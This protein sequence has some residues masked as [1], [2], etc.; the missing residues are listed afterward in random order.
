MA[1]KGIALCLLLLHH[2]FYIQK[3]LYDDIFIGSHGLVNEIGK[4]SK[5]CVSIFVFLSGYGLTRK[6]EL[7]GGLGSLDVFYRKRMLKILANYWLIW[8]LFVPI[9]VLVFGRSF[10]MAY[11]SGVVWKLPVDACG[12]AYLFGFYGYNA[13]WWFMSCIIFLYL[14]FPFLY[15]AVRNRQGMVLVS[16]FAVLFFLMHYTPR[17]IWLYTI[18]FL[19]GMI[20]GFSGLEKIVS[21]GGGGK[22]LM[23][24][25]FLVVA[26]F[27]ERNFNPF[28]ILSDTVFAVSLCYFIKLC[29]SNLFVR[30]VLSFIG[31]HSMNIFL[32]HT[33]IYS[34]WFRNL[35]YAP[36]N[37]IL[38]FLLL[39]FVCLLISAAIEQ[40]KCIIRFQKIINI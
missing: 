3:G 24:V 18:P 38:I 31:K 20:L 26:L 36:R 33:F 14:L 10:D 28:P 23:T 2:L 29:P 9:G 15:K 12:L 16:T 4:C 1:L 39:L 17:E 27:L 32:F 5:A 30:D 8:L 34:H 22:M 19:V 13:T 21:E 25:M 35:I 7:T 6:V 11:H 37:P 40:L